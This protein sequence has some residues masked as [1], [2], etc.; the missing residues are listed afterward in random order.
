MSMLS[1]SALL[2]FKKTYLKPAP[3]AA[4]YMRSVSQDFI[5]CPESQT[6]FFFSYFLPAPKPVIILP[7]RYS[8][9]NSF[10]Q[11]L[12]PRVGEQ[13]ASRIANLE[14]IPSSSLNWP[15]R[16]TLPIY[17]C[18]Y[19]TSPIYGRSA[20][21]SSLHARRCRPRE[22]RRAEGTL[23]QMAAGNFFLKLARGTAGWGTGRMRAR[24]V[25]GDHTDLL[26]A[27]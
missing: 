1:C 23:L 14:R 11:G 2:H 27:T 6:V 25:S 21:C 4:L 13:R 10:S 3:V 7:F 22:S 18:Q 20:F 9:G 19:I 16:P 24:D 12:R 17:H 8:P 15:W 5:V 26:L